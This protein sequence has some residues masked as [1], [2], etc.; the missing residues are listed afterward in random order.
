MQICHLKYAEMEEH[1]QTYKGRIVFRGDDVRDEEGFHA[2][3][4][5]QGA[6]S[7]HIMQTNS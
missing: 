5:D 2:V 3:F 4:S 7:A 1:I 6:S